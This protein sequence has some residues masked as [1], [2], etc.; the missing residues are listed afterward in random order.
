MPTVLPNRFG[1]PPIAARGTSRGIQP[2]GDGS[3]AKPATSSCAPWARSWAHGSEGDPPASEGP[4]RAMAAHDIADAW[5]GLGSSL[6]NRLAFV[7]SAIQGL[8]GT[9]NVECR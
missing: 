2:R 8:Q 1:W 3:R 6:D 4:R 9:A 7:R 5:I